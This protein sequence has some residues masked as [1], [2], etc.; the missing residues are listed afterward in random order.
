MV[1]IVILILD[2]APEHSK[3]MF[4]LK[5]LIATLIVEYPLL[6]NASEQL[7]IEHIL[8]HAITAVCSVFIW[9]LLCI[10]LGASQL[11]PKLLPWQVACWGTFI[12]WACSKT[13][14]LLVCTSPPAQVH[15]LQVVLSS[16]NL[17]FYFPVSW[18]QK[19]GSWPWPFCWVERSVSS[20]HSYY[21]P[22]SH[23]LA[24]C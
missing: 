1:L 11:A 4:K 18:G 21:K 2:E 10:E 17:Q 7:G 22:Y 9:A 5:H 16:L 6:V 15:Y 8:V 19:P 23:Q 24:L 13:A 20:Y 12:H 14:L 3:S